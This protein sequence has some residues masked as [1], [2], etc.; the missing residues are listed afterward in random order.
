[1]FGTLRKVSNGIRGKRPVELLYGLERVGLP[2]RHRHIEQ[3]PGGTSGQRQR[4]RRDCYQALS[5]KKA[6]RPLRG[7]AEK[8]YPAILDVNLRMR[9]FRAGTGAK[10]RRFGST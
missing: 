3:R 10:G 4:E 7:G 8:V 9:L 1:M 5:H 6:T 2:D